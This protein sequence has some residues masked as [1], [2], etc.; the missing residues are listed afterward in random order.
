MT[1]KTLIGACAGSLL[2]A[3][4]LTPVRA[5]DMT[6]ERLL[7]PQR[8]PQ[9]WILHHGNYQGHR[10]SALKEINTDTVKNLRPAFTV[11]LGGFQSGGRYAAGALEATPLVEDGIMY[12]PDGWGSVY[13]IDVTAGK[14]GTIKWKM[15][16][17]TDRAWAGDVACCGVNN[18]GVALWKDKVISIA[19]DGRMFAINKA[20]GEVVWERKIADPALG[21][22]LTIAPL[23]IRDLAIVGPA[24][25]EFGIRGYIE[26]TDLNTGKAGLADLHHPGQGR[27]RQRDLEGRQGPLEARRRLDLGDRDLRSGDRH[28]LPGHRQCRPGLRH[29]VSPGRQQVGGERARAQP[30]RRQD[31]VGLPVHPA[32]PLR[33]RRDL[34]APDHQRQDQRPGP[35]ARGARRAQRLLLH[36][37]PHQ[38]L[39]HLRQAVC[40][41]VELDAR[42]RSQDRPPAQLRSQQRYPDLRR[43]LPWHART[44][45]DSHLSVQCRR[46]ELGAVRLQS[47]AQ[48]DLHSLDRRLQ[49]HRNARAEGHGGP[50]RSVEVARALHRRQR[51]DG[52]RGSTAASRRSIP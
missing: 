52:P 13:A 32:G 22:T 9:N 11:A 20:T 31:Q 17:G 30:D 6:N 39:V 3:T 44:G 48:P 42:P 29:P 49:H 45:V 23:I 50:G 26:A 1:T 4:A 37:R 8:E 46:Q 43:R 2:M 18:R 16:P 27:T 51:Q 14:K 40:G 33:L 24:G 15:D 5:A 7:N 34:R 35:Q 47:G 36:A 28:L 38:R 21:E 10:F 41:P 12:V 19:L 25:G